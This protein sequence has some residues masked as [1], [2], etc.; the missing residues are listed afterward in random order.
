MS[1]EVFDQHQVAAG[2]IPLVVKNRPAVGGNFDVV[3]DAPLHRQNFPRLTSGELVETNV[4]EALLVA[5]F[6]EVDTLFTHPIP[7]GIEHLG[8]FTSC[9]RHSPDAAVR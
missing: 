9:G 3:S 7:D 8:F 6:E 2:F 4:R 5:W 1:A